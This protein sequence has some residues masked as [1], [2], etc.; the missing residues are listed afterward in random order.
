MGLTI[1]LLEKHCVK[2]DA[3][4]R[5]MLGLFWPLAL[6]GAVTLS[7]LRAGA[8]RKLERDRLEREQELENQRLL[9]REVG[10]LGS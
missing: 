10:K 7:A 2:L 8:K 3:F 1:F 4:D 9:D 5:N 6:P